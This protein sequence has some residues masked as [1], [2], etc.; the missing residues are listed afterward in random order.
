MILWDDDQEKSQAKNQMMVLVLMTVLVVVWFQFFM[1][2][3]PPVKPQPPATAPVSETEQQPGQDVPA[4]AVPAP[5]SGDWP[6]LPPVAEPAADPASDEMV[7][8]DDTQRLTFT[9]VGARLKQ[10]LVKLQDHRGSEVQLVPV[11]QV[12]ASPENPFET[13]PVPDTLAV[14]PLGLRFSEEALADTLNFRRWEA[15]RSADGRS[16]TFTIEA[17]GSLRVTKTFTLGDTPHVLDVR[18]D[19]TSLEE[20]PRRLGMDETPSF[21]LLWEP[22]VSSGDTS[23]HTPPQYIWRVGEGNERE[24]VSGVKPEAPLWMHPVDWAAWKSSYFLVGFL[25]L[26]FEDAQFRAWGGQG[27]QAFG[28]SAPRFVA[29]PGATA[30]HTFRMYIGPNR[31]QDLA[32]AW[33]TL[34]TVVRFF[35]PT[36]DI[37]DRFAKILLAILN[38][39]YGILPNYGI[40][41]IL[42]T[43]LVRLLMFP[44]TLKGMKGMKRMQLLAPEMEELKKKYAEDQQELN[45]KMMELYKEK[46]IN[47]L[48]GCLPLLLQM[49]VFIALYRMLWNAYELRGA[50]FFMWITDLSEPDRLLHLPFMAGVPWVGE[51]FEYLNVLPILMAIV[52]VVHQKMMPTGSAMQNDQQKIIMTIMPVFMGFVLYNVAAGLNLYILTSTLLGIVQQKLM[53]AGKIEETKKKQPRKRQHF[54][55]AAQARKRRI[56][57]DKKSAK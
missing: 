26:D 20:G 2:K 16:V 14:Y 48:G 38:W 36:W 1:P 45:K 42:L 47:P 53:P 8:E 4:E 28:M 43:I 35:T 57:K 31:M 40:A 37:M 44:L 27:G 29:E 55:T 5:V 13:G 46:G 7:I 6:L 9:R 32:A 52:M 11:P 17:P 41:I 33:E 3:P 10:A 21:T 51:T 18:V 30:S 24:N 12:P 50:P 49:P 19:Y 23:R 15:E 56:A 22:D 34:P 39:F 25:P 54:Y